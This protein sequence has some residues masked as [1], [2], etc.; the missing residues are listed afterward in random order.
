MN[1]NCWGMK[2]SPANVNTEI[3][4]G[5][6]KSSTDR[7]PLDKDNPYHFHKNTALRLLDRSAVKEIV[8]INKHFQD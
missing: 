7:I 4:S 3:I 2:F 1:T 5:G 6:S 8:E